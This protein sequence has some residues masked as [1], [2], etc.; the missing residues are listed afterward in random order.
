MANEIC[1]DFGEHSQNC[2]NWAETGLCEGQFDVFMKTFCQWSCKSCGISKYSYFLM[3]NLRCRAVQGVQGVPWHPLFFPNVVYDYYISYRSGKYAQIPGTP[4]YCNL[5]RP[6]GENQCFGLI[7]YWD[8]KMFIRKVVSKSSY[9]FFVN[10]KQFL[11]QRMLE[12]A[13]ICSR[14]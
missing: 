13:G 6:C 3:F 8:C 9:T 7:C 4:S 14:K 1:E 11:I 5:L 2:P 12:T 10:D